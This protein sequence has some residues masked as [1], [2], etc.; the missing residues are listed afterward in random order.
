MLKCSPDD[1]YGMQYMRCF[2][3]VAVSQTITAVLEP[4]FITYQPRSKL[5]LDSV[6][7]IITIKQQIRVEPLILR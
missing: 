7:N 5:L 1:I 2:D 4:I 6:I 3:A